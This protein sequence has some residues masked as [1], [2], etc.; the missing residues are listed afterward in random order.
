MDCASAV[1]LSHKRTIRDA[2]SAFFFSGAE[3]TPKRW[4]KFQSRLKNMNAVLD[5]YSEIENEDYVWIATV[6]RSYTNVVC[7]WIFFNFQA[8]EQDV[9]DFF[10]GVKGVAISPWKVDEEINSRVLN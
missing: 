2:K 10:R 7:G 5:G 1:Y 8:D 3:F 4:E 9:L 6:H